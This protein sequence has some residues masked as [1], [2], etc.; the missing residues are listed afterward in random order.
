M[1]GYDEEEMSL[2][3]GD[4]VITYSDEGFIDDR[5]SVQGQDLSDYWLMNVARDLQD[6][7]AD[8]SMVEE[9]N[10]ISSDPEKLPLTVQRKLNINMMNSKIL[11]R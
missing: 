3:G 2:S 7:L 9:L 4:K 5:E 10:L 11:K 6:T 8:H 1:D